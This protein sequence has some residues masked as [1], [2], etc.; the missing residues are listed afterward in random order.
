MTATKVGDGLIT[1]DSIFQGLRDFSVT[2]AT[3]LPAPCA[4]EPQAL[5]TLEDPKPL[6]AE[7]V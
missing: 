4:A 2:L 6:E 1:R 3:L 5:V 7:F